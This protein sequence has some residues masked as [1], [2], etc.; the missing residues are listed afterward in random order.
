MDLSQSFIY[1]VVAAAAGNI[2][3]R[4][5]K[6]GNGLLYKPDKKKKKKN[7][8]YVKPNILNAMGYMCSPMYLILLRQ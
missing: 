8:L 1:K 4:T 3:L 7:G 6:M 5:A 2:K